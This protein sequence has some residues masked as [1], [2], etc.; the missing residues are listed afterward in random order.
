MKLPTVLNLELLKTGLKSVSGGPLTPRY[1]HS[2]LVAVTVCYE[3]TGRPSRW[4]LLGP[5]PL[6]VHSFYTWSLSALIILGRRTTN[7]IYLLVI[8]AIVFVIWSWFWFA[9]VTPFHS[10]IQFPVY[11][12]FLNYDNDLLRHSWA[13]FIHLFNFLC[14]EPFWTRRTICFVIAVKWIQGSLWGWLFSLRTSSNLR[15]CL[16]D[17]SGLQWI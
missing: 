14:T 4:W 5:S 8:P 1:S 2:P 11:G 17:T 9:V 10:F 13:C 7:N 12:N 6:L 15:S 3:L 16:H